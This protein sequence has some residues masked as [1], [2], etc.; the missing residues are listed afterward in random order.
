MFKMILAGAAALMLSVVAANATPIE[1]DYTLI[2][3]AGPTSGTMALHLT[4]TP[5]LPFQN[6]ASLIGA[7][8]NITIGGNIFSLTSGVTNLTF[9]DTAGT[10]FDIAYFGISPN[11]GGVLNTLF[12][13]S[14]TAGRAS[15]LGYFSAAT[16][17]GPAAVPEPLTLSLF[18]AGLAGV[19]ALRRRRQFKA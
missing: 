16:D 5:T 6:Y 4:D 7:G 18:G 2:P 19:A 1:Y 17:P 13:Y 8:S 15:T 14:Y 9:S 12:G 3:I 11:P 10:I